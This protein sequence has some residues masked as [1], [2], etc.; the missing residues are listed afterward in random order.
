M[1]GQIFLGKLHISVLGNILHLAFFRILLEHYFYVECMFYL[2]P[3]GR[4]LQIQF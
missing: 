3:D 1:I 2:D 4:L